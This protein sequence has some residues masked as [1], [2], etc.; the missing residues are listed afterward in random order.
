MNIETHRLLA[1][2]LNLIDQLIEINE[3]ASGFG[4]GSFIDDK[5]MM[6]RTL[7]VRYR[8]CTGREKELIEELLGI[9]Y[10]E[11]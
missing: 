6:Q 10:N 11:K 8:H 7:E 3:I 2:R 1:K 5:N 4:I 9:Y